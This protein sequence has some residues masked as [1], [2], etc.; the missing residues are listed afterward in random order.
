MDDWELFES[1]M[2]ENLLVI[3]ICE[4]DRMTVMWI[5]FTL[6]KKKVK[7]MFF[8]QINCIRIP[9]LRFVSNTFI[10]MIVNKAHELSV[11]ELSVLFTL[12]LFLIERNTQC[13]MLINRNERLWSLEMTLETEGTTINWSMTRRAQA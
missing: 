13:Q 7:Q 11:F 12:V 5:V 2:G 8:K 10:V 4:H 1:Q 9:S 3:F 6:M